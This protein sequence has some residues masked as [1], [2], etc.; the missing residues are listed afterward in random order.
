[1]KGIK[2]DNKGN[3]VFITGNTKIIKTPSGRIIKKKVGDK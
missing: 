1:M 3:L 2:F